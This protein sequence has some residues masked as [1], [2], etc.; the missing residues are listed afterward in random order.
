LLPT[1]TRA[2]ETADLLSH[3]FVAALGATAFALAFALRERPRRS[4]FLALGATLGWVFIAR[5]LDGLLIGA[6]SLVVLATSPVLRRAGLRNLALGAVLAIAGAAP[7]L[8]L[9]L[10]DQHAA[11]GSWWVPTQ[12]EYFARSDW[13]RDCHRLGFGRDIGCAVEHPQAREAFAREGYTLRDGL[14]VTRER[15]TLFSIEV[16]G[17]VVL[18][19]L[20]FAWV[21]FRGNARDLALGGFVVSF[22]A[23]YSLFYYGNS[24]LHGARHLFAV[25]PFFALLAARVALG[26]PARSG[27]WFDAPHTKGA[28]SLALLGA[29]GASSRLQWSVFTMLAD[30]LQQP[31]IDVE[32]FIRRNHLRSGLVIAFDKIAWT[33]AFDPYRDGRDLI[34]V[35]NDGAGLRELRRAHPE[36]QPYFILPSGDIGRPQFPPV[37]GQVRIEM[38]AAWPSFQR[39]RGLATKRANTLQLVHWPSNG[40]EGLFVFASQQGAELR[41]PFDLVNGGTFAPRMIGYR[42]YDFGD[43]EF[44]IDGHALPRWDGFSPRPMPAIGVAGEPLTLQPGPH[45]FAARCVGHDARSEDFLALWDSLVLDPVAP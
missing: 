28:A 10:A 18:A 41:F 6:A 43:Y 1:Y 9:L 20:V 12:Y 34:P 33:A 42:S 7:F 25:E 22:T 29:I 30:R 44:S 21:I 38:E 31:R 32:Q 27:R 37:P 35:L 5:L 16:V 8:G 17:L 19:W 36:V 2:I 11:T 3:A 26:L 4:L 24:L 39:V 40:G 45:E 13:P 14:A 23:A 15:A